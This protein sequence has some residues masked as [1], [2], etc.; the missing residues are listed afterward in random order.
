MYHMAIFTPGHE[1]G[2]DY[3]NLYFSN[4]NNNVLFLPQISG[5]TILELIIEN[6]LIE[7][8]YYPTYEGK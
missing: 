4:S 2:Y 7:K 6:N 1:G 5:S 3:E 8:D